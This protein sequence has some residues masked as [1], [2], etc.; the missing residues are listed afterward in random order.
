M[1]ERCNNGHYFSPENTYVRP[2][3]GTR[4][5]RICTCA[6]LKDKRSS[7]SR[8][9]RVRLREEALIAYESKCVCCGID[10]FTVLQ[11]DH[12]HNAG[13][14]HRQKIGRGT[15]KGA[16]EQSS[17]SGTATFRWL[18]KRAWPTGIVQ[19]LCVNCHVSKTRGVPCTWHDR[20]LQQG[21][22]A[23]N[24]CCRLPVGLHNL[25]RES[26]VA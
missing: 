19:I 14:A 10:D 12:I 13:S 5:C 22:K 7:V 15:G 3:T 24:E 26:Q 17:A 23:L 18:R 9:A 21:V 8:V 16:G 2:D 6:Y 1:R 4:R 25:T 20:G 11:L